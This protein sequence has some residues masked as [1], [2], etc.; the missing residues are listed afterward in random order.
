MVMISVPHETISPTQILS[1]L[2]NI[3]MEV[4]IIDLGRPNQLIRLS[5]CRIRMPVRFLLERGN[6]ELLL[7]LGPLAKPFPTT[8][9]ELL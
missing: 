8:V 9:I 5:V 4:S 6:T 3:V 1:D 7:N 2:H